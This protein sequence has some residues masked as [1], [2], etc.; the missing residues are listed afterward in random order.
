MAG[1]GSGLGV[2]FAAAPADLAGLDDVAMVGEP[3]EQRGGHFGV[4]ED[5]RPFAEI[6]IGGQDDRGLFVELGDQ[7]KQQ[8]P[9]RFGEGQIAKL[10]K[11]DE[12]EPRQLLRGAPSAAIARF[13][14]QPIDQINDIEQAATRAIAHDIGGDRDGEMGFARAGFAAPIRRAPPC[15]SLRREADPMGA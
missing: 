4:A 8:L 10:I 15:V 2:A 6:E 1:A 5:G 11:H 9:G 14:F 3:I 13:R 7:V 12:I